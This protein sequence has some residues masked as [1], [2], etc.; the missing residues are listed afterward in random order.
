MASAENKRRSV[1]AAH[2]ESA[3]LPSRGNADPAAVMHLLKRTGQKDA[4]QPQRLQIACQNATLA[5]FAGLPEFRA[6]L[7][8][9]W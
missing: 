6:A 2:A 8:P 3:D 5:F 9:A 7:K 1:A 4:T